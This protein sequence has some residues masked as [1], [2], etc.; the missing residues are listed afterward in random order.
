MSEQ[1]SGWKDEEPD[2]GGQGVSAGPLM[3]SG[4]K[5]AFVTNMAVNSSEWDAE[6]H[7]DMMHLLGHSS[8]DFDD[9]GDEGDSD[10]SGQEIWIRKPTNEKQADEKCTNVEFTPVPCSLGTCIDFDKL[11]HTLTECDS[12]NKSRLHKTFVIEPWLYDGVCEH[13]DIVAAVA[14]ANVVI[15]RAVEERRCFKIGITFDPVER[16]CTS[17]HAYEKGS[18][19]HQWDQMHLVLVACRGKG[20]AIRFL[21]TSGSLEKELISQWRGHE[22]CLNL[23][24]GGVATNSGNPNFCY[25]VTA[26]PNAVPESVTM[27]EVNGSHKVSSKSNSRTTYDANSYMPTVMED[28][29]DKRRRMG[30]G[31]DLLR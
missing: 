3:I 11:R 25:V 7:S 28:L 13:A 5:D 4:K 31:Y 16:M 18:K 10:G 21:L 24:N 27:R 30:V 20:D 26:V 17:D 23:Q 12:I 9:N 22:F 14:R 8:D 29:Q 19:G 15:R 1:P 2:D 6:L